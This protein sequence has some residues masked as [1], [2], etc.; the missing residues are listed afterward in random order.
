MLHGALQLLI[1]IHLKMR[2]YKI[3][4]IIDLKSSID[5]TDHINFSL[6]GVSSETFF[7]NIYS[8]QI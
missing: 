1:A 2:V 5:N 7:K 8:F 6:S 3:R 4:N